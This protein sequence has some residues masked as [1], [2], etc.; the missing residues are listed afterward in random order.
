MLQIVTKLTKYRSN[1]KETWG[2]DC[3]YGADTPKKY[4]NSTSQKRATTLP[5][6]SSVEWLWVHKM[7]NLYLYYQ[8]STAIRSENLKLLAAE[9]P[10]CNAVVEKSSAASHDVVPRTHLLQRI[11][12]ATSLP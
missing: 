12:A 2:F 9:Y 4:D 3:L 6:A 11:Q 7:P 1:L 5:N 8:G 10:W